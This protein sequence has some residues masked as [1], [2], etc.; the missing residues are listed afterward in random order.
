MP[1]LVVSGINKGYNLGD[2]VTYSGTVSGAIEGALLG[3]PSI[4]VSLERTRR[5]VRFRAMRRPRRHDRARR[6]CERGLAGADVPEH[7][8][9]D[10]AS[11]RASASPCRQAQ[12]RHRRRRAHRPARQAVLLDRGRGERLGAARPLGLPGGAGR[13]RVGDAAAAGHDR[14]TM[15]LRTI[16]SLVAEKMPSDSSVPR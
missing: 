4:A 8:R 2:D 7:Q 9:A 12:P 15:R 13:L 1:D 3:I 14:R 6:C 11:R 10:R 16:E 5:R